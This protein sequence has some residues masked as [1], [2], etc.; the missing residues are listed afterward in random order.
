M[1]YSYGV[2][3]LAFRY[4]TLLIPRLASSTI[5]ALSLVVYGA[6]GALCLQALKQGDTENAKTTVKDA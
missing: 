1:H 5:G 6:A 4:F 3:G 2:L